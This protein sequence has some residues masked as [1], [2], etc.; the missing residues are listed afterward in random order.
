MI[1]YVI[2]E[3][4]GIL[5]YLQLAFIRLL[6]NS[7]LLNLLPFFMGIGMSL[8]RYIKWSFFSSDHGMKLE[9]HPYEAPNV[10]NARGPCPYLNTLANHGYISRTGRGITLDQVLIAAKRTV[11]LAPCFHALAYKSPLYPLIFN[12]YSAKYHERCFD[13]DDLA[14]HNY[15]MEHDASLTRKDANEGDPVHFNK[16]LFEDLI[17]SVEGD[18]VSVD[19]FIRARERR[20]NACLAH[21]KRFTFSLFHKFV[22][23]LSVTSVLVFF[24]DGTSVPLSFVRS[25]FVEEKFP[26]NYEPPKLS[27]GLLQVELTRMKIMDRAGEL[28]AKG[29]ELKDTLLGILNC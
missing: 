25:L 12:G 7:K 24:G 5:V 8:I 9:D 15:V 4:T 1:K 28:R 6:F 17:S 27:K 10:E 21:N 16:Q 13:L 22:A 29:R 18:K 23:W 19:Q 20:E 2:V 14:E 26:A 3:T 11:N